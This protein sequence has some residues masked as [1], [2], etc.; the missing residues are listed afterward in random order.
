MP[1]GMELLKLDSVGRVRAPAEKLAEILREFAHHV[2]VKKP[3]FAGWL[4]R[5]RLPPANSPKR[6]H[7]R[8]KH[9][10]FYVGVS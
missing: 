5:R 8:T 1:S 3:T 10:E 4:R 2:G 6:G 9:V 7:P